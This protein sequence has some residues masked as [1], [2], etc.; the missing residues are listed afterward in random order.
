[1]DQSYIQLT[2]TERKIESVVLKLVNPCSFAIQTLFILLQVSLQLLLGFPRKYFISERQ[3][4]ICL[5]KS[6]T[7][8]YKERADI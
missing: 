6:T 2:L 8:C 5:N 3:N 7:D 4:T 1:M